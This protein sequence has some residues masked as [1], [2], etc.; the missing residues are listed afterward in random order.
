MTET[1]SESATTR[2]V[3]KLASISLAG[4]GA[5]TILGE[6]NDKLDLSDILTR[7]VLDFRHVT[8]EFWIFLLS[9]LPFRVEMDTSSLTVF[10]LV[11]LPVLF[12]KNS[13]K[14]L[15][16]GELYISISLIA[17]YLICLSFFPGPPGSAIYAVT[18]MFSIG[19]MLSRV[20]PRETS[21]DEESGIKPPHPIWFIIKL[22]FWLSVVILMLPFAQSGFSITPD[23]YKRMMYAI[24]TYGTWLAVAIA[25]GLYAI[26]KIT[27]GA[28][29]PLYITLIGGGIYLIDLFSR[30]AKP[31]AQAWLTS[32]GA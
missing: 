15:Q 27:L 14:K 8:D 10:T 17:A 1:I 32:I 31:A 16:D 24:F 2:I 6:F 29:G 5:I 12:Q 11:V 7:V 25:V 20:P 3:S 18:L 23:E 28:P 30:T 26:R 19:V 4:P 21:R 13:L 9:F 22:I